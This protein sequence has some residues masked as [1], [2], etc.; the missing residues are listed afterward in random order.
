MYFKS[1]CF[2]FLSLKKPKTIT[3]NEN[4]HMQQHCTTHYMHTTHHILMSM[5]TTHTHI[6]PSYD[7]HREQ[8]HAHTC[9]HAHTCTHHYHHYPHSQFL[10]L[11]GS[12]HFLSCN[13]TVLF[14]RK[15]ISMLLSNH[16]INIHEIIIAVYWTYV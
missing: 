6:A 10:V 12:R 7:A 15:L 8:T 14:C 2:F 16:L 11:R 4:I 3:L 13:L 5:H 1:I 9:A